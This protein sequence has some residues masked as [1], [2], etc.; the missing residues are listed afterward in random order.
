MAEYKRIFENV[1]LDEFK[2]PDTQRRPED[3]E[4]SDEVDANIFNTDPMDDNVGYKNDNMERDVAELKGILEDV[5]N[6]TI[7]M[8]SISEQLAELKRSFADI[9]KSS[10]TVANINQKLHDLNGELEGYIIS[11][12]AQ[13][14]DEEEEMAVDQGEF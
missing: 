7:K 11:L 10:K 9:G 12:P 2:I 1:L 8:K 4:I 13:K 3:V 6:M 5:S 14:D